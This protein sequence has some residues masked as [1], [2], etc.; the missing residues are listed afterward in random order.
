MRKLPNGMSNYEAIVKVAK[1]NNIPCV[2]SC[3]GV[4]SKYDAEDERCIRFSNT[5]S[6]DTVK[7][8]T[9]RD[10]I[11]EQQKNYFL[12]KQIKNIQPY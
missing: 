10:D 3:I 1:K 5:L 11:D 12:Q 8:I 6:D 2:I 4:E 7:I 9:T